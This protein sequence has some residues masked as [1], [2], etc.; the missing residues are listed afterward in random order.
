LT[1]P[2]MAVS[3]LLLGLVVLVIALAALI[4]FWRSD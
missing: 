4:F 2:P 3:A 1:L